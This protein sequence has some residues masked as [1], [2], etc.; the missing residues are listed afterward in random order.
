MRFTAAR[1]RPGTSA[2]S[3]RRF[4]PGALTLVTL[5]LAAVWQAGCDG[6]SPIE[7]RDDRPAGPYPDAKTSAYVLPYPAGF[8]YLLRQGGGSSTG[9]HHGVLRH[10]YDF[11]MPIGALV[12][13]ARGGEVIAVEEG[14]RDDLDVGDDAKTNQ[15]MVLHADGT[16]AVYR[17]LMQGGVL[18]D[19]GELVSQ[20]QA[21]GRSGNTG[22]PA[23]VAHLHFDVR[24]RPC[25]NRVEK[26]GRVSD[27]CETLAVS[28]RNASPQPESGGLVEGVTYLAERP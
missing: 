5:L 2:S 14:H 20:G 10:A 23:G 24:E 4:R 17:H 13:A 28:F 12:T 21:I 26:T 18:V 6:A 22:T 27:P 25:A 8:R 11:A 19:M 16:V 3:A 1:A 15:V 7:P 9:T